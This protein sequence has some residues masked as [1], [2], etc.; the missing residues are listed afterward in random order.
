MRID[1]PK[2][3]V[4]LITQACRGSDI[5]EIGGILFGEH[6]GS[7][8]FKVADI[9]VD[10][11]GLVASFKRSIKHVLGACKKFFGKTNHDYTRFNY[12]GE[13]HS[14][15]RYA[16][17]PSSRDDQSMIEIVCDESVGANFVILMIVRLDYD[18]LKIGGWAYFP[19]RTRIDVDIFIVS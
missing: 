16:I 13:W 15:P 11:Q 12:L 8:H 6:I 4:D 9:T 1:F 7:N 2:E 17:T 19:D 18:E 14:H 10:E 5:N 3:Y